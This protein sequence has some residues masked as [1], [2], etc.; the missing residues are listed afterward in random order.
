MEGHG[1]SSS[2]ASSSNH[3]IVQTA[4]RTQSAIRLFQDACSWLEFLR[5]KD[6]ALPGRNGFI[7]IEGL[8]TNQQQAAFGVVMRVMGDSKTGWNGDSKEAMV[9]ALDKG[10]TQLEFEY[11]PLE[12]GPSTPGY[13]WDTGAIPST[14]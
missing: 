3:A 2:T 12:A 9:Q 5:G 11:R 6:A 13:T 10:Y 8:E 7:Q 1:S 14:F 4:P